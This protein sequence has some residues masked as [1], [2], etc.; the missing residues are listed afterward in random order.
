MGLHSGPITYRRYQVAGDLPHGF[1]EKFLEAIQKRAHREI[2]VYSDEDRTCGWTVI[3]DILDTSLPFDRIFLTE[4]I[5]LGFRVDTLRIPANLLKLYVRKA[6]QEFLEQMAREKL[7]K[8]DKD[9]VKDHVT[10]SLRKRA[11]PAVHGIDVVWNIETGVVRFWSHNKTVSA[12]FM[13]LFQDTFDLRLQDRTP[14]TA[15]TMM[16]SPGEILEAVMD[17]TP[18]DFVGVGGHAASTPQ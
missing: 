16:S 11:L 3:G 12:L 18:S 17:S 6:E 1:R 2:D 9:E 7:S 15:L 10:K 4:N 8:A 5:L 14:Y 13:E